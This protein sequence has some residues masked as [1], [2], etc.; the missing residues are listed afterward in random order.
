MGRYSAGRLT[1]PRR[2]RANDASAGDPSWKRSRSSGEEGADAKPAARRAGAARRQG[3]LGAGGG[4]GRR[5]PLV[6]L[7]CIENVGGTNRKQTENFSR[8]DSEAERVA[9]HVGNLVD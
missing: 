2:S 5:R 3:A 9:G 8:A 6:A 4:S 7:A 1:S